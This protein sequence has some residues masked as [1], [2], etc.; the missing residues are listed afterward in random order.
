MR[1][2]YVYI[3]IIIAL[4]VLMAGC[5]TD[6]LPYNDDLN[7]LHVKSATQVFDRNGELISKIF[8]ENRIFVPINKIS[9]HVQKAIIANED[10]RFYSHWGIDP[11]GILRALANNIMKGSIIEGGSTITQ[12]LAKNMFLTQERT[13]DRKIR[14]ALLALIIES[15]FSKQEI[16]QA[17]LNQVYFGEGVYGIEAASQLYFGKHANEL[18]IGESA[19]LAGL[20]RG[21]ELFSPYVNINAAKERRA[22][23]L[24]GMVKFGYLSQEQADLA[25]REPI[26]LRVKKKRDVQASY[27]LDYLTNKMVAKHGEQKVFRGGLK[28]YTTLDL[29]MQQAAESIL[30]DYQGAV[31]ILDPHNGSVLAM[32]GGRNYSESQL[33]RVNFETRQPGSTIKP[34]VYAEALRQGITPNYVLVDEPVNISGYSPQ[35][36]D[37]KYRGP[38][39]M[40]KALRLSI[41]TCSVKMAQKVGVDKIINLAQELG[42]TTLTDQ[43]NNLSLALGGL[44]QGVSLWELASAY[45]AF[46]NAGTVSEPVFINR[47]IDENGQILE[48]NHPKQKRVLS[49]EIAYIMTNMLQGVIENGS[50]VAANIGRPSAGKTGT[51][52]NYETAWFVGYTPDL[53]AAIYVG[54]DNRESVGISGGEVAGLWSTLMKKILGQTPITDFIIPENIIK[55]VQ[56]CAETGDLATPK[57]KDIEKTAFIKGTEPKVNTGTTDNKTNNPLKL[58]FW[59]NLLPKLP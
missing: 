28:I 35:N 32:V 15:K 41:N 20:P 33:N 38:I 59:R 3:I 21:P 40:R 26:A 44:T 22:V 57:C 58:P 10:S 51:T 31:L 29:K 53:L 36:Y 46:A 23:V 6:F 45:T 27:F 17:Y 5:S 55:D 19:L 12:Q 2:S 49:P 43:D 7:Q 48:E 50:G 30:G 54:N 13:W 16:L 4:S 52:D 8:E 9:I 24:A 18:T 39:T 42:I 34:F 25:Q 47:V 56:I 1:L 14:E 37:K 11:I